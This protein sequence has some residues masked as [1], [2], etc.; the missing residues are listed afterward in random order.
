[1]LQA[2]IIVDYQYDSEV[3]LIVVAFLLA[4]CTNSSTNSF[5]AISFPNRYI[6]WY[7]NQITVLVLKAL[8]IVG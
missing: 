5:L 3:S 6:A 2:L 8:I 4:C 7:I 1:V